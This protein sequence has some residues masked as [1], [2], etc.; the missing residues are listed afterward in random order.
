MLIEGR[1]KRASAMC[2]VWMSVP[3]VFC[4][5]VVMAS[6][7]GDGGIVL[8]AIMCASAL[9]LAIGAAVYLGFTGLLAGFNTMSPDELEMYDMKKVSL[10]MGSSFVIMAFVLFF[11][12]FLAYLLSGTGEAIAVFCVTI[13]A[14]V[15]FISVYVSGKRFRKR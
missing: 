8:A 10:F 2:I 1:K 9:L 6:P 5:Y 15:I 13:V 14:G 12:A 3:L 4:S 7:S 11:G